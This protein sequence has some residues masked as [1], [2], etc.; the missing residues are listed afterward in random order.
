MGNNQ[1]KLVGNFVKLPI[2]FEYYQFCHKLLYNLHIVFNVLTDLNP[3]ENNNILNQ[4]N[5]LPNPVNVHEQ[6]EP[7]T[8]VAL[9]DPTEVID[10][11]INN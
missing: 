3:S 4:M 2:C 10:L 5:G 1:R 7:S 9:R 8:D 6:T 11:L